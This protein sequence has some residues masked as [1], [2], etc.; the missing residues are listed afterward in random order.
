MRE[1]FQRKLDACRACPDRSL[2]FHHLLAIQRSCLQLAAL[3]AI[4]L[5][6]ARVRPMVEVELTDLLIQMLAPSDGT[7]LQV[8]D[9]LLPT[10]RGQLGAR[11]CSGWYPNEATSAGDVLSDGLA[12]RLEQ[13]VSFRNNRPGHGV[14]DK[15]TIDKEFEG[16]QDLLAKTLSVVDPLMPRYVANEEFRGLVLDGFAPG[17]LAKSCLSDGQNP[18]VLR[19]IR[20]KRGIW[21]AACQ[22]LDIEVSRE[23]NLRVEANA[24]LIALA[25]SRRKQ[26]FVG[27]DIPIGRIRWTPSVDLPDRQTAHFEG[28]QNE[29]EQL[30]RWANDL[31]SRAILLYGDGGIGKTTLVLEFVHNLLENPPANLVFKPEIICFYS[32]KMTRWTEHGVLH[33]STLQP[34]VEDAVRQ[35][36]YA[37]HDTL[38]KA[39]WKVGGEA[40]V[41][42]VATELRN[43]GIER[44]AIL[45]IV[46]NAETLATKPGEDEI[47][48]EVLAAISRKVARVLVTSRRR[49]KIEALPIEVTPLD[50]EA[51]GSLLRRLGREL[52]AAA[53]NAAG[54]A[55]LR[56]EG[57]ALNGKPILLEALARHVAHSGLSIDEAKK[58]ILRD[59]QDGLSEFLYQDAWARMAE[60]HRAVFIVLAELTIPLTN[61][62]VGWTCSQVGVPHMS[63]QKAFEETHFGSQLSYGSGYEVE[64]APMAA[65]F[66]RVQGERLSQD[67]RRT[68][69]ASKEAVV[70]KHQ[71]RERELSTPADDRIEK[72]FATPEA[73]AAK[74][75]VR[76]GRLDDANL[77]YEEAIA[78]DAQ[79]SELYDRYA[80]FLM[81]H[82]QNLDKAEKIAEV[83]CRLDGKNPEAHFT[84]ALILYRRF[85]IAGGDQA[86]DLAQKYGKPETICHIQKA[87]ARLGNLKRH[88]TDHDVKSALLSQAAG[89]LEKAQKS[90]VKGAYYS[91][92]L[93]AIN[94]LSSWVASEVNKGGLMRR[95]TYVG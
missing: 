27:R 23:L 46:D 51:G 82:Y 85:D 55:R 59:A 30:L 44:N 13:W 3:S 80:W 70:R 61:H 84:R 41:D 28:R 77:W 79:N 32:A 22:T 15:A 7:P 5:Y 47:L 9:L 95:G 94:K 53:I 73:R 58:Q 34:V 14:M 16:L 19:H 6:E 74:R 11:L 60:E 90:L 48:G 21:E 72:A 38:D 4:D 81:Q 76:L 54:M 62:V 12:R 33:F 66:F 31:E 52:G 68:V 67:Q 42:R 91:K 36:L 24:P 92:N 10:I 35:L 1:V 37:L 17:V 18:I 49:E 93:D 40:L 83:A 8:L 57:R 29:L 26:R 63:W 50:E 88:E 43:A 65:A 89:L 56:R 75:C 2:A 78:K 87:R 71:E 20:N 69:D 45:L 39:W 86:V 25:G 64:I